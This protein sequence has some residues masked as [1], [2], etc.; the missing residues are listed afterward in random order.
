MCLRMERDREILYY[1]TV[2]AAD[3]DNVE[4]G[5]GLDPAR[6]MTR[7]YDTWDDPVTWMV[8]LKT[9]AE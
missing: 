5:K 4:A 8:Y 3:V 1:I 6:C 2:N 9:G 7:V